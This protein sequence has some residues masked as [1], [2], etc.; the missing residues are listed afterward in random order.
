MRAVGE[1]AHG[2]PVREPRTGL[3][4]RD[5]RQLSAY[6]TGPTDRVWHRAYGEWRSRGIPC[7]WCCTVRVG[8]SPCSFGATHP[9]LLIPRIV[10]FFFMDANHPL[11]AGWIAQ[12]DPSSGRTF[13]ANTVTGQT[14]WE[15]PPPTH[16]PPRT[17]PHAQGLQLHASSTLASDSLA[18]PR[19]AEHALQAPPSPALPA[20]KPVPEPLSMRADAANHPLPAGWIAQQDPGRGKRSSGPTRLTW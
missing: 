20:S 6:T 4:H 16:T 10:S 9:A 13:Y 1:R 8:R 7:A 19:P 18:S 5:G 3:R 15:Q 12:Q 11:P 17:P 2:N 14:Q